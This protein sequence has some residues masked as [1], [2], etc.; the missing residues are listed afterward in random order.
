M[1]P[2]EPK[3]RAE[4]VAQIDEQLPERV[5][6]LALRGKGFA[7]SQT[8]NPQRTA[9]PIGPPAIWRAQDLAADGSDQGLAGSR[10]TGT[11]NG[12]VGAG[13]RRWSSVSKLA[14]SC[15]ASTT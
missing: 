6:R 14:P 9:R 8:L 1:I 13:T 11:C 15:S 3:Q 5:R 7:W 2:E 10:S 4:A 12:N